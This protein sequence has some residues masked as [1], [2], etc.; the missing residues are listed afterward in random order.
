MPG[1]TVDTHFGRLVRRFGWTAEADPVKV[2]AEVGA[3]CSPKREWTMFSHRVIF[4]GRRVCHARKPACGACALARCARR[5]AI[6]PDRPRA[7]RQAGQDAGRLG[8]RVTRRPGPALLA[9]LLSVA[10]LLL[11]ACGG[12]SAQAG[13]GA[14]AGGGST[15][16]MPA[17]SVLQ[18][19]PA[20]RPTAQ[21]A[22][23]ASGGTR[24]PDLQLRC[25]GGARSTSRPRPACRWW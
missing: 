10:A 20:S 6:G 23:P 2:E 25:L 21:P 8:H 14:G 16:A 3:S 24:L 22:G 4:H 5:T 9:A 17:H 13:A 11:T 1:L 19:C 18:P 12:S 15:Q 7:R